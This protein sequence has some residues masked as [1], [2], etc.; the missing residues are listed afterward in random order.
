MHTG[1]TDGKD[2]GVGLVSALSAVTIL[3]GNSCH[4][5]TG[6]IQVHIA[7]K[8]VACTHETSHSCLIVL[9]YSLVQR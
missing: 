1:D 4:T 3:C 2:D 6:F 7:D 5:A 9:I 8:T